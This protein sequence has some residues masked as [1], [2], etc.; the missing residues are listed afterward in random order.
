M[1]ITL[2]SLTAY[3]QE[4]G[5]GV[6]SGYINLGWLEVQSTV[7]RPQGLLFG[8]TTPTT[9]NQGTAFI[10]LHRKSYIS[11]TG[12]GNDLNDQ[13]GIWIKG[14]YQNIGSAMPI[15]IGG[16]GFNSE[17]SKL[18]VSRNGNIGIGTINP[19]TEFNTNQTTYGSSYNASDKV[20]TI[21]SAN[22]P[23][24]ELSRPAS[25]T[26]GNRIGAIYFTN[27]SNQSDAHRQ[28]AGIWVENAGRTDYPTLMGGRLVFMTKG[29]AGGVQNKITM[30]SFGNLGIGTLDTKGYKLAVAGNMIAEQVKVKLQSGWPDYV[31]TDDYALPP[32]AEVAAYIKANKHLPEIPAAEEIAREGLDVGQMNKRLLKKV[33]ELTLYIIAQQQEIKAQRESNK[34]QMEMLLKLQQ[35]VAALKAQV[36]NG[37]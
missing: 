13:V 7:N 24:L 6:F 4:P 31:F 18:T 14:Y 34:A 23:V 29:Y 3:C 11:T 37:K 5:P 21:R 26:I 2:L 19:G 33:E 15:F 10:G 30:D 27:A 8:T 28:V 36:Q 9:G 17:D 16:E 1:G 22:Q 12:T 25:S 32:L 35:E 20:L